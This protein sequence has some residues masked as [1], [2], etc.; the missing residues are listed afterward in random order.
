[1]KCSQQTR[2]L[3]SKM[4]G[5]AVLLA[6]ALLLQ[7]SLQCLRLARQ[8][9]ALGSSRRGQLRAAKFANRCEHGILRRVD[10]PRRYSDRAVSC[11]TRQR[12]NIAARFA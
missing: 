4:A 2:R 7:Y 6:A 11:D 5:I 9:R 1:M 8:H 12:P 10:V 3:V